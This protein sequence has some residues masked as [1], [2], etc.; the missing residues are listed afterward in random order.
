MFVF[1]LILSSLKQVFA[2]AIGLSMIINEFEAH[3]VYIKG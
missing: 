3:A 1:D 2:T